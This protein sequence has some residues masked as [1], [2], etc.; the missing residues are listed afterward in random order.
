[1]ANVDSK[2][3]AGIPTSSVATTW[4][5]TMRGR[6]RSRVTRTA[7][8]CTRCARVK[9]GLRQAAADD[10]RA[11]CSFVYRYRIVNRKPNGGRRLRVGVADIVVERLVPCLLQRPITPARCPD[12]IEEGG[13]QWLVRNAGETSVTN[14]SAAE[15][16]SDSGMSQ[17]TTSLTVMPPQCPTDQASVTPATMSQIAA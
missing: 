8:S 1:M 9:S 10:V 14:R 11:L 12:Q 6:P 13:C 15:Q 17:A 2:I 16:I 4:L 7:V 5:R 3:T